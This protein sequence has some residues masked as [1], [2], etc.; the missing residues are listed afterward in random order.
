MKNT[1]RAA[2]ADLSYRLQDAAGHERAMAAAA[3]VLAR[4]RLV[5]CIT[6]GRTG[7]KTLA[8]RFAC[9]ASV[10]ARHEPAP[11][12]HAAMRWAQRGDALARNFWLYAKLPAIGALEQPI[13][14]ETSHLFG[15]GFFEPL[16]AIGG[17][18]ALI[19]LRRD[20]RKTALSMFALN[21]IPG[22]S[23]RA[24][25]YYLS[26]EDALCVGL[27][28][29]AGLTDYQLCYWHT[30]EM[31]ARQDHFARRAEDLGLGTAY[32]ELS[33]LDKP[34]VFEDLCASIGITL[35]AADS[36]RLA[37]I[38]AHQTH[39]R[40]GEKRAVALTAGQMDADEA[41]LQPHLR[42]LPAGRSRGGSNLPVYG[43]TLMRGL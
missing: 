11:E 21:D 8:E 30:V 20:K 42:P 35:E 33:D 22:R 34:G 4:K 40:E 3:D 25:K 32:L 28:D 24:I 9:I 6:N 31:E 15:K 29:A 19:M 2:V 27:D 16:I 7:T 26:P 14:L 43:A 38:S 36:E 12:F 18:P 5:F 37:R 1:L 10:A 39:Q 41:T 17:R 23:R 13:Y